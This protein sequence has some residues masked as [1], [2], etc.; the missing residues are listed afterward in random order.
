MA[1]LALLYVIFA[2]LAFRGRNWA[3]VL[4]TVMTVGFTLLLLSGLF[5]GTTGD[6]SGLVVLLAIIVLSVGGT[7]LMYLPAAARFFAHP[8]G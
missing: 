6:A 7:V 8:R 3:R 1:V 5:T 2:V 4:V